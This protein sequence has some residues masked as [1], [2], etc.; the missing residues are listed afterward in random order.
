LG[1]ENKEISFREELEALNE[2]FRRSLKTKYSSRTAEKHYQVVDL[3]IDFIC[4]DMQVNTA[5][6]K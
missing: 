4:W 1:K 2:K 3:F 6:T 5:E